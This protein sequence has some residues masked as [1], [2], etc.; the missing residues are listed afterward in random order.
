MGY[1]FQA[2]GYWP[3]AIG[4][5]RQCYQT[6]FPSILAHRLLPLTYCRSRFSYHLLPIAH[7]LFQLTDPSTSLVC[8]RRRIASRAA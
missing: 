2:M 1:R 5:L 8:Q 6:L 3:W 7:R 4:R